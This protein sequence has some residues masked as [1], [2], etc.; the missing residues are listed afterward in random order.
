MPEKIPKSN[1]INSQII[2]L[3]AKEPRITLKKISYRLKQNKIIIS[4]EGIRK[5]I[6]KI[7]KRVLFVPFSKLGDYGLSLVVVLIKIKGGPNIKKT[8]VKKI[9][10]IGSFLD[11]ITFGNFDMVSLFTVNKKSQMHSIISALKEI[12]LIKDFSYLEVTEQQITLK[13]IFTLNKPRA[14]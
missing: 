13:N 7:I 6:S 10:N 3:L 5:R 12:S 1:S 11:L 4:K 8:V 14:F 9:K 2:S